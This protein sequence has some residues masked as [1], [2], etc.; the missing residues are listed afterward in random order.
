[1]TNLSASFPLKCFWD[2]LLED[3]Q[4]ETGQKHDLY[5]H[6]YILGI[7]LMLSSR[8]ST[9][10]DKKIKIQ[11]NLIFIININMCQW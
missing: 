5:Q 11:S 7:Q 1:M 6:F 10:A 4:T 2:F 9:E 3:V 8:D